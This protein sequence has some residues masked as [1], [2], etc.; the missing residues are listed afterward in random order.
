MRAWSFRECRPLLPAMQ[1]S[2]VDPSLAL[3]AE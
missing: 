1:A 2:R 3:R